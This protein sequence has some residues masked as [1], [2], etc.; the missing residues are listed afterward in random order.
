MPNEQ[1]EAENAID[2]E[3]R[4]VFR[5]SFERVSGAVLNGV[6]VVRDLSP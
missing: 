3:L 6:G 4:P 1:T 2:C 5:H